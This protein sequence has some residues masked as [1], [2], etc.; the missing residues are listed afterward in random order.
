MHLWS[1]CAVYSTSQFNSVIYA[2]FPLFY[3]YIAL[4]TLV[5]H[6]WEVFKRAN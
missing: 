6:I 3:F 4:E 1:C 5:V 2:F